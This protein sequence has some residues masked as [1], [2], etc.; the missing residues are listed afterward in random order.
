MKKYFVKQ[1]D[2]SDCGA[3]SLL[4]IIKY[5]NGYVPLEIVKLDTL[6][7]DIGTNLYN[8]KVAS[9]KYGFNASGIKTDNIKEIHFP[10]I[11][12]LN[13]SGFNHFVTVYKANN[14]VTYIDSAT[15]IKDIP[16]TEFNELFT[17]YV[18]EIIPAGKI[19]KYRK[20]NIFKKILINLYKEHLKT[21]IILFLLALL[22]VILAL[23]SGFNPILLKNKRIIPIVILIS[24]SKIIISYLKNNI[25][26]HLNKKINISLL[27]NYLKQIF[28]L[29]L[30]YLQLKMPGDF[31]NRINDLDNVKNIFSKTILDIMINSLLFIFSLILLFIIEFKLTFCL[32]IITI[33]YIIFLYYINKNV[34]KKII[35]NVESEN[36]L[37]DRIIEYL[38]KIITIK[39][40]KSLYFQA[41]LNNLVED[42]NDKKL[43]LEK[44]I[45][46]FNL[47]STSLEELMIIIILIY[48]YH[49]KLDIS[50]LLLYITIYSYNLE[51]IK[52][53]IQLFPTIMYFKDVIHRIKSVYDLDNESTKIEYSQDII[54]QNVSYSYDNITPIISNFNLKIKSGNKVLI[55]GKNGSGK[56]TLLNIIYGSINDYKGKIYHNSK[57]NYIHQSSE[58][59][60]GTILE[61]I[62]LNQKY[63]QKK[64]SKIIKILLLDDLINNKLKGY[65]FNVLSLANLSGGE[66]QKII[67]A[68]GLYQDF[69]ILLL[70]ESLNEIAKNDRKI[71]LNNIFN[72]YKDKTIIY[73]SHYD[74]KIKFDQIINLAARKDQYVDR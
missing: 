2:N 42:S 22:V 25:M 20:N 29:P 6:T 54:L 7:N 40:N 19:I 52:Y 63:D 66:K 12:Q 23:G 31:I 27:N 26:S 58:L 15:G 16:L 32:L 56:S 55:N 48:Y 41:Q 3:C 71:I 1:E 21:I 14:T 37:I 33:I 62:I 53:Y 24:V 35:L 61:N 68:R 60:S 8:I 18:L 69:G 13:V 9:N 64:L 45:N 67:L 10:C 38:N 44:S 57:I 49:F 34:Y 43:N 47:I 30:K 50:F 46:I 36:I 28:N 59:I 39:T 5:Y 11:A 72:V 70:D 73:I 4:S 74:D 51:S 17:G 65:N